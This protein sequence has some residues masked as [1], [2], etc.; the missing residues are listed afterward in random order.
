MTEKEFKTLNR[1]IM[2]DKIHQLHHVDI[3]VICTQ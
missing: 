1:L 2:Y 3:L